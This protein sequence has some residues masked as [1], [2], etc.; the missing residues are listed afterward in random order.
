MPHMHYDE[1]DLA[2]I[3]STGRLD[4]NESIF[5][6]RELDYVKSKAYDVKYPAN[7]ALALFPVS[8]EADAGADTIS[9]ESYDMVGMAKIISN[10]ADDL[11]RADVKGT[12]NTVKVFSIGVSYGYSTKDIRR[13]RMAGKNLLPAKRKQLA[14]PTII[15]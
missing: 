14:A 13:S 15:P 9:Y 5:F 2:A 12:L 10:Y 6:A 4:A 3:Q 11:P 1:L 8:S 7:N